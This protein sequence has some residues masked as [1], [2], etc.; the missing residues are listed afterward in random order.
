MKTLVVYD[1]DGTLVEPIPTNDKVRDLWSKISLTNMR[2]IEKMKHVIK[3]SNENR[4][5][6]YKVALISNRC[7]LVYRDIEN[8]LEKFN[9]QVD[10]ILLRQFQTKFHRLY[11]LL[12]KDNYKHVI[13]YENS[14]KQ[15]NHYESFR[16]LMNEMKIIYTIIDVTKYQD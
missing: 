3:F 11:N 5:K 13:I 14:Q 8:L 15:I 10:Y 9:I 12:C 16:S 4:N 1:L 2:V 7:I 6:D